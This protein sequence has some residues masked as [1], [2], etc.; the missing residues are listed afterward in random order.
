VSSTRID[1]SRRNEETFAEA[2]ERI[3]DVAQSLA[4]EPVPFLC[5]C[6]AMNCTEIVRLTLDSYRRVRDQG[7][8]FQ[9]P[10]H[11][12]PDTERVVGDFTTYVVVEKYG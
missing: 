10:G 1:R 8:F 12:D 4:V 2:N 5:E 11:D 9:A 7:A 3:R 6:S